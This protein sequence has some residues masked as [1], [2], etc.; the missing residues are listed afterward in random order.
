MLPAQP[1]SL[2]L[3]HKQKTFS[4]LLLG[5]SSVRQAFCIL[6]EAI[7]AINAAAGFSLRLHRLEA[8][9]TKI[10]SPLEGERARVRG[11]TDPRNIPPHPNPLPQGGEGK[12]PEK[13]R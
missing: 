12:I 2:H 5:A 13:S 11:E 6:Q 7:D 1:G 10:P 4:K 9:A 3:Y 8:G